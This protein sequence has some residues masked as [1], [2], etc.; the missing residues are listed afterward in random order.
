[1]VKKKSMDIELKEK[2]GKKKK[3]SLVVSKT[4]SKNKKTISKLDRSEMV[5]II[6]DD[7][8]HIQELL[9]SDD[10]KKAIKLLHRRLIQMLVDLI[11]QLETGIRQSKGRYGVHS[12][13]G[14]IQSIR[15][16][17]TDLQAAQ[18]RSALGLSIVEN[19]IRPAFLELATSIMTEASSVLS[20]VKDILPSDVY[21]KLRQAQ[22]ESRNR[23]A[24][25]MNSKYESIKTEIISFLQR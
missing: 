14:M 4:S 1:M 18:D 24:S 19:I 12:L 25:G 5:S 11:P 6:G 23:L 15:E 20:E 2:K 21:S 3:T 8:E 9:E 22:I 10:T 17:L 16:L 7:A 13:N